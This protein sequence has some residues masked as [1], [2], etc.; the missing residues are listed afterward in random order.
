V[1]VPTLLVLGKDSY[2]SYEHL[3][4]A[5]REAAGALLELVRVDGGH[6]V[7]WDNLPD[8]AA[9]VSTFLDGP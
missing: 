2:V 7:L 4:D 1:R 3:L 9:A 6:T 5:H 8:T